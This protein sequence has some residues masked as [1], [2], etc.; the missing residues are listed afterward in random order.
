M[1][2]VGLPPCATRILC[3]KRASRFDARVRGALSRRG[4]TARR[5]SAQELCL[6]VDFVK[7]NLIEMRELTGAPLADPRSCVAAC[8]GM[9]S[10]IVKG[11]GHG[12]PRTPP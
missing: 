6:P 1:T 9:S 11:I 2:A 3:D 8:S 10:F 5:R 12:E 7:P 4:F